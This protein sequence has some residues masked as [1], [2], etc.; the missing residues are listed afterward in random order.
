MTVCIPYKDEVHKGLELKYAL[1]SIKKNLIGWDEIILI[2]DRP[3][4]YRGTSYW[5]DYNGEKEYRIYKRMLFACDL[6]NVSDDF[7]MWHDD[8]YLLKL[9]HVNDIKYWYDHMLEEKAKLNFGNRHAARLR[10]TLEMFP[11]GKHFDIHVPIIFNK[12]KLKEIEP[13]W[14]R[15][16]VLKS[17]YCNSYNIEGEQMEEARKIEGAF[18]KLEIRDKINGHLFFSTGQGICSPMVEIFE[19]LFP[20]KSKF[21]L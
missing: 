12:Q 15:E 6:E 11:N 21:E 17:F 18:S 7:V 14:K 16:L 2:G 5:F 8:H 3:D 13:Q 19:E 1:R 10:N 4:W 9:L 20:H